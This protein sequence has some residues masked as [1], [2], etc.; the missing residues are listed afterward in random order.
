VI[1]NPTEIRSRLRSLKMKANIFILYI[2]YCN[3]TQY[4]IL[5]FYKQYLLPLIQI[6]LPRYHEPQYTYQYC[7]HFDAIFRYVYVL[8]LDVRLGGSTDVS[9][10]RSRLRSLKMK[11]KIF[12]LYIL[13]CNLTQYE[14]LTFYKQY[15]LPLIQIRPHR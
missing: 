7:G 15:L 2:L 8:D 12:I 14:T 6:R 4:D 9:S 1:I 5:T 3:L 11:A 10:L 13:Y